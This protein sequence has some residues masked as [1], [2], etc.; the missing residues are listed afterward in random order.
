MRNSSIR[1]FWAGEALPTIALWPLRLKFSIQSSVYNMCIYQLGTSLHIYSPS[2][3][4]NYAKS[5]EHLQNCP[6]LN[7]SFKFHSLFTNSYRPMRIFNANPMVI[8]A[9]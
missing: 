3:H 7:K 4:G 6:S 5:V 9:S 1:H 8:F 2:M